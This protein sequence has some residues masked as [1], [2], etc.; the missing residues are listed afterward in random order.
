M[1][2]KSPR[3]RQQRRIPGVT[4]TPMPACVMDAIYA[5]VDAEALRHGVSR[6]FVIAVR[7]AASYGVKD[8]EQF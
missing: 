5:K 2:T 1:A 6:S 7:L 3:R 8:Q 4:R